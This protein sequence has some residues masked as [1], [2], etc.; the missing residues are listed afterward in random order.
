VRDFLTQPSRY[1]MSTVVV[2]KDGGATTSGEG[3]AATDGAKDAGD[4]G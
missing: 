4:G 3:G 2:P 1:L